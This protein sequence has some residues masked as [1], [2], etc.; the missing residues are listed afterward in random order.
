MKDMSDLMNSS[1]S[2]SRKQCEMYR[3]NEFLYKKCNCS[4]PSF[5]FKFNRS[6][7]SGAEYS[8]AESAFYKFYTNLKEFVNKDNTCPSR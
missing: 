6:C 8:C 2:Y 5:I 7:L 1:Y 4:D 3:Y